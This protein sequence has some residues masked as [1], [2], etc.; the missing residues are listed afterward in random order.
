MKETFT[1]SGSQTS[2]EPTP[3][4]GPGTTFIAPGGSPA[5][6]AS[7]AR[8][9][10]ESGVALAGFTTAVFPAASAG[11]IFQQAI[12]NGK[13]QGTI[14]AQGPSGLRSV[15]ER[16]GASTGGVDPAS[17]VAAPA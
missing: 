4:P 10:T 9:S 7:S 17:W 11:A 2:A 6:P 3:S 5:S 8:R 12:R 13:F 16:P 15:S 1:T 14:S